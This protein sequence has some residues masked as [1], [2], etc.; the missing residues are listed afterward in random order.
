MLNPAY[1]VKSRNGIFYVRWPIPTQLHP[2]NKQSTLKLSLRTR[3]P[4][5]ALRLSRSLSQ[6]G[7]QLNDHGIVH[8][9][10]YGEIR[11]LLTDHF[12][13]LL[14]QSQNEIDAKGRLTEV[15]RQVLK[16]SIMVAKHGLK[17]DT[18]LSLVKSDDD[19]LERFIDKYRL[20]I[21]KG[22]DEYGWLKQ[23]I[24][25]SYR[26]FIKAVLDYDKSLD[27]YNFQSGSKQTIT[28]LDKT[29]RSKGMSI[30]DLAGSYSREKQIGKNWVP[31]TEMEKSEHIELLKEV[32]GFD[33]DVRSLTAREAKRVKDT[34]LAYPKNR[35]KN[36]LTRTKPLAE[37]LVLPGVETI[38][39]PT[40][41]KYLQTY[42]DMFEWAKR[43]S[44]IDANLFSGLTIRQNKK[45]G[46]NECTDFSDEQIN[47][48]LNTVVGN[49]KGLIKK[50]YQKW[51]PL[52]GIYTGAR[53]NEIAQIHLAD[54]RQEDGIWCFDLNE[55]DEGKHLKTAAATRL[56]PIHARLIQMG[57]IDH[58]EVMRRRG[59]QKLF[60][61]FTYSKQNGW[62]RNLGRWFNEKLLPEL[63]IKSK[64]LVFHSLRHTV[65]TRLMHAYVEEP[66]VKA[67]VGHQ[68]QGVTQ[69]HYFK[70]YTITQLNDALQKLDFSPELVAAAQ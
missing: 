47:I 22:S 50:D 40:I 20:P 35:S 55:D 61:D 49:E 56:V 10:R 8:G 68:Q 23:E 36:P 57:L 21:Q 17:T 31:K 48:I 7:D 53:L 24:K 16:S 1:L 38:Q 29:D 6:I 67:L 11:T 65:V 62:G 27:R 9:M 69:Q 45:R 26:D 2:Q 43:N 25:P 32:L 70:G 42:S 41:N 13:E 63:G 54:I 44:H 51:G 37:V 4:R 59:Q 12:R 18:P 52:I 19:L 34:L 5:K 33:T 15:D 46:Q 64:E 28:T 3:D 30:A 66:I 58:V 14:E 39:V 60:P